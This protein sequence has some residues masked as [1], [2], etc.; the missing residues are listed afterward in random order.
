MDLQ[1]MNSCDKFDPNDAAAAAAQNLASARK[2]IPWNRRG[3][4]DDSGLTKSEAQRGSSARIARDLPKMRRSHGG[5][6]QSKEKK[7]KGESTHRY[8]LRKRKV[9]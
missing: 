8:N 1:A 2:S 9:V 3:S 5:G 7:T 6:K 4:R